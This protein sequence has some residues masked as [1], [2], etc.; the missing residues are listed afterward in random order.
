MT[1]H[2]ARHALMRR[3]DARRPRNPWAE[4]ERA[5]RDLPAGLTPQQYAAA[6]RWLAKRYGV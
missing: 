5:K 2:T 3:I 1:A 4:Y 6:C